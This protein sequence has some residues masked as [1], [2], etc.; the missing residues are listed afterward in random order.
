RD[1][2]LDDAGNMKEVRTAYRAHVGRMLTLLGDPPAE[3]EAAVADVLRIETE[4]ARGQQDKVTRR[5]PHN[6]YHRID[7]KGLEAKAASFPWKASRAPLGTPTVTPIPVTDPKYSA[8]AARMLGT[9]KPAALRHYLAWTLVRTVA[10]Q[11]GKAFV[12]EDFAL[13]HVLNGTQ[14]M[15]PR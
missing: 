12:A 2:Y 3:V 15:M 1:Y 13:D 10:P 8:E 5:D 14:E 11:L 4:L 6:I 7:L 9:E